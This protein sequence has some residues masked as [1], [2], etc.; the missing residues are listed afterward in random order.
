M[1]NDIR[2]QADIMIQ[3]RYDGEERSWSDYE[4]QARPSLLK[5]FYEY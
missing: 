3:R 1:S 5:M 4:Q 2:L